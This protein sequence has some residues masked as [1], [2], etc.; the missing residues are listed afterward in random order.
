MSAL[1]M[2]SSFDPTS[3]S[4]TT[5]SALCVCALFGMGLGA[6]VAGRSADTNTGYTTPAFSIVCSGVCLFLVAL[7][8]FFQYD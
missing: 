3:S 4:S 8:I 5:G 2:S 7:W 1:S 6:Y